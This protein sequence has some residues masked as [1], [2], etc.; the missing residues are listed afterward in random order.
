MRILKQVIN[1]KEKIFQVKMQLDEYSDDVWNL[2]NMMNAGDFVLGS[3]WRKIQFRSPIT[4]L[5]K[6]EKKRINVLLR[7]HKFDYDADADTLR[8]N[9][10]NARENKFVGLGQH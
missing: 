2:Y 6:T 3:C 5:V 9:G 7:V 8:I 4:G 10:V 1:F